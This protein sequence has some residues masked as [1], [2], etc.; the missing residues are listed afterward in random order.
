VLVV[1]CF[2]GIGF[3]M[4]LFIDALAFLDA[5]MLAAAKLSVLAASAVAGV[6]GL[7]VGYKLLPSADA[8]DIE[9]TTPED[10][11]KSTTY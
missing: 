8:T 6:A 11:E 4:A 1:G 5:S 9:W 3:T 2:A 7:V 10:A